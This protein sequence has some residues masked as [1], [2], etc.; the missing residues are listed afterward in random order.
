M[1][2]ELTPQMKG[3]SIG[4]RTVNDFSTL[5]RS[6]RIG[7]SDRIRFQHFTAFRLSEAS[8][9]SLPWKEPFLAKRMQMTLRSLQSLRVSR[10]VGL[11]TTANLI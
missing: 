6:W 2:I 5:M 7:R 1:K 3:C 11:S 10:N 8:V 9:A 4:K